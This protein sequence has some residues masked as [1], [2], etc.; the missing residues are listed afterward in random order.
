VMT[1]TFPVRSNG[2]FFIVVLLPDSRPSFRGD[3]QHRTRNPSGG[4]YAVRWIPGSSLR[5]APE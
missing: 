5:D 2:V 4:C 3:A 1:A